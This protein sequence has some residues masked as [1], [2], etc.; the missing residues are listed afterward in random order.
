MIKFFRK[1][2]RSLLSEGRTGKYLKYAFGEI[3][4]V[5][6][7]ILIALPINDLNDERKENDTLKKAMVSVHSDMLSDSLINHRELPL[8]KQRYAKINELIK[9]AYATETNLDTLVHIMQEEFPVRWYTPSTYNINTFSN[10][11]STGTFDVLPTD[12]KESLSSYYTT[13]EN[14]QDLMENVLDQYRSHLDDF[15]KRYN[16]IGRLYDENYNNSYMYNQTWID[17]DPKDFSARVAVILA[18]YRVLYKEAKEVLE[19]NQQN[20][21]KILPLLEPYLDN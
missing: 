19:M 5:V 14:N 2:R 4:L 16:I 7:G 11:K 20:I 10:L 21:R 12:I 8:V 3:I 18:S 1:I 15:V 9:I 6:I 13:L 17:I